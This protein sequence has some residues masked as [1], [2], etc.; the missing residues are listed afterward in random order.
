M[1]CDFYRHWRWAQ[2]P[3]GQ[4]EPVAIRA[5]VGMRIH[6]IPCNL[7]RFARERTIDNVTYIDMHTGNN[8]ARFASTLEGATHLLTLFFIFKDVT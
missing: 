3:N 6:R 4:E 8:V 2:Q 1:S 5:P 7:E